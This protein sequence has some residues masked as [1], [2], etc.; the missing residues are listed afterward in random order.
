MSLQNP[1]RVVCK[2]WYVY[3]CIYTYIWIHTYI[4]VYKIFQNACNTL[5]YMFSYISYIFMY[6]Q[7]SHQFPGRVV[8]KEW[9]IHIYLIEFEYTYSLLR[10]NTFIYTN[11]HVNIL[12]YLQNISYIFMYTQMSH[13]F[14]GRVVCKEWYV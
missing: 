5:R 8:C 6:T 4:Y 9:Y 7:M 10:I 11:T 2:E 14:P 3:I 13:Q 12:I 1:G